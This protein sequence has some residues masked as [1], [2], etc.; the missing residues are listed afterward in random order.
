MFIGSHQRLL[1]PAAL[2]LVLKFDNV[3]DAGIRVPAAIAFENDSDV[4]VTIRADANL[5]KAEVI[6]T[7]NGA[8]GY[9][10]VAATNDALKISIDE[11]VDVDIVLTA[12]APAARAQV[13]TEI[14]AAFVAAVGNA[15]SNARAYVS[16]NFIVIMSGSVGDQSS[17]RFKAV[18]H[19]AAAT[20][21]FAIAL[22]K[23]EDTWIL[24]IVAP[25]TIDAKGHN[26]FTN[27]RPAAR[28]LQ[29]RGLAGTIGPAVVID[30]TVLYRHSGLQ[31]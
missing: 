18:A 19:N 21:G 27:P 20:L 28:R 16:G 9:A 25:I 23:A 17:V 26:V 3:Q 30:A 14:N 31:Q 10:I 5:D 6:S 11:D 8:G 24:N 22:T 7:V 29:L 1:V 2:G 15:A 13:I 12:G 4:D